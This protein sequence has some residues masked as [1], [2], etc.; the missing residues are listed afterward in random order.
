MSPC[1]TVCLVI[2]CAFFAVVCLAAYYLKKE[3]ENFLENIG[4]KIG[5]EKD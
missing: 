1:I 3:D 4:I 5:G 2:F